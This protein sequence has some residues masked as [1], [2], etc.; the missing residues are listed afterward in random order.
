MEDQDFER[1]SNGNGNGLAEEFSGGN[2]V[3]RVPG[4]DVSTVSRFIHKAYNG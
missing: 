4:A 1:T 2:T 3:N